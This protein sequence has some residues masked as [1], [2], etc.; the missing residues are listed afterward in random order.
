MEGAEG[1]AQ[2]QKHD[3]SR[4]RRHRMCVDYKIVSPL[5]PLR[6]AFHSILQPQNFKTLHVLMVV[7]VVVV[8]ALNPIPNN[9]HDG[10]TCDDWTGYACAHGCPTE[11]T[12]AAAAAKNMT[13][14]GCPGANYDASATPS[15]FPNQLTPGSRSAR[16]SFCCTPL[17]L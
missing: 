1:R 16:L 9:G 8:G 6:S 13:A 4:W 11:P 10:S 17:T 2:D 15:L 12:P 7:P 14:P 3:R 5:M